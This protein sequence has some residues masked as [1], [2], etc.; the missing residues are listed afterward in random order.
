MLHKSGRE[1]LNR[2][3]NPNSSFN[4]GCVRRFIGVAVQRAEN[5]RNA[6]VSGS[7]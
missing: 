4:S 3:S 5:T 2:F 1:N 6:N 7:S